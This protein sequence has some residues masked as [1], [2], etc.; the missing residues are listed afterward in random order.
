MSKVIYDPIHSI[1]TGIID[2][3]NIIP[4]KRIS[5]DIHLKYEGQLQNFSFWLL[6]QWPLSHYLHYL[7]MEQL[8]TTSISISNSAMV[9]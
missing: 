1:K 6:Q 9:I 4:E 2:S 3:I 8:A 7:T 5:R